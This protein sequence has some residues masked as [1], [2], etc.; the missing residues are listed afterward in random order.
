[1]FKN[2]NEFKTVI[3]HVGGYELKEQQD[4]DAFVSPYLSDGSKVANYTK[5]CYLW[6]CL[7]LFI[8]NC[9]HDKTRHH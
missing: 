7:Q 5:A 8:G 2:N 6:F 1:M 4:F 3:T 9:A